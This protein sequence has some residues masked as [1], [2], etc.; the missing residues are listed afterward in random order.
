MPKAVKIDRE[1]IRALLKSSEVGAHID[2]VADGV[3]ERARNHSSVRDHIMDV[4][5][6]SGV[7]DRVRAV[8]TIMHPGGLGVQAKHGVLSKAVADS[9]LTFRGASQ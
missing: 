1:G 9:G 4:E 6:D 5:T 7:S 8:V 3:A 2:T